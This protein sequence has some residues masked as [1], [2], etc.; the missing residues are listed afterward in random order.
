MDETITDEGLARKY[1]AF[2][3]YQSNFS[4]DSVE[5][6]G[7]SPADEMQRLLDL[8]CHSTCVVLDI[9]CGAGQTL[10]RAARTVGSIWGID[11]NEEL[12]QAARERVERMGLKNV[13]LRQAD[14]TLTNDVMVLS[15]NFFD[16]A[17]SQR[18]PNLNGLLLQKMKKDA[19]FI[20]ELVSSF[21]GYPLKEIFGRTHYT[22]YSHGEQQSLQAYYAEL[23][24]FPICTK[25]YFYEEYY[26]DSEH[27]EN[28]L[29]HG[30][31]LDNWRLS[32]K[33]FDP[34]KDRVSLELYVKYNTTPRGIRIL[35][36]RRIFV[37]RRTVVSYYPI[38]GW[39]G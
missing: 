14:S 1:G 9:G 7:E 34:L 19:V 36:Q 20:Q 17:Y 21:D 15:D 35:R 11:R 2:A 12:L 3:S 6:Y 22:P 27:L 13:E 28:L 37:L 33:P 25:E 29:R 24:L 18:G 30:A 10:C 23:D 38:D 16:L 31:L 8:Y 5:Y 4:P 26:R 39:T 32:S